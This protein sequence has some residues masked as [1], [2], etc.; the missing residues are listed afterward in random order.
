MRLLPPLKLTAVL[1]LWFNAA[2]QTRGDEFQ[3]LANSFGTTTT[4]IG[5]HQAETN[6][7]GRNGDQFLADLP[8]KGR[9]RWP[10]RFRIPTWPG[11]MRWEMSISPTS[12]PLDSANHAG[13]VDPHLCGDHVAGFDGDGPAL[14]TTLQINN[15]NG[16][17]RFS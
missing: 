16:L 15:P 17:L 3:D 11:R 14:A 8:T 9:R 7:P 5:T 13:R 10:F 6:N 2:W 12:E 1:A 4:L